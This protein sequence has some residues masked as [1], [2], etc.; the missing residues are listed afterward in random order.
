M[1]PFEAVSAEPAKSG[2]S[3][4]KLIGTP[5]PIEVIGIVPDLGERSLNQRQQPTF[6]QAF[7]Y[8]ARMTILMR[9]HGDV[10]PVF[11]EL[12]RTVREPCSLYCRLRVKARA[13]YH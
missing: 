1:T 9:V 10:R 8:S 4:I 12:R 6:Y 13:T 7:P 11:G 3:S 2:T 5:V